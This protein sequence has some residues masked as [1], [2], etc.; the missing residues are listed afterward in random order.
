VL[1]YREE[2]GW[3]SE[4][5][6]KFWRKKTLFPERN[7]TEGLSALRGLDKVNAFVKSEMKKG[8]CGVDSSGSRQRQVASS[9]EHGNVPLGSTKLWTVL[10][11]LSNRVA[12]LE[13]LFS[14]EFAIN[15]I[16]QHVP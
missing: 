5:V 15:T 16:S 7:Q 9:C 14:M 13:G 4:S 11:K 1:P 3:A 12:L 6:S 10:D 8:Y 2:D